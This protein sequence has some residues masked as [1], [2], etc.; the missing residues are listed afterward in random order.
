MTV[1][2]PKPNPAD[3][4]GKPVKDTAAKAP[5]VA[6]GAAVIRRLQ[7][8][9]E[10]AHERLVKKHVPAWVI[11]GAVHL[12]VALALFIVFG[13]RQAEAVQSSKVLDT[14][15]EKETEEPA[16]D[17]TNE[18]PGLESN[19]EAAVPE[20]DR[21][22]EKTVDDVVT[23]DAI[24]IPDPRSEDT[25]ALKAPGLIADSNTGGAPGVDGNVMGGDGGNL[26]MIATGGF[27][28][29]GGATK[30][31]LLRAGGG[32][33]AS[34][35]AVA[36]GLA[37]LA[38]QQKPNG[39]WVYDGQSSGDTIAATGMALLP[40]L[41]AGETHKAGK[42][43]QQTVLRGL[44][45]LI[46][47]QRSDGGFNGGGITMYSHGIATIALNEAY[48][49][50]K[51]KNMLLRPAQAAT[52]FIV[53]KQGSD[54]SWGYAP[55]TTGD[56]SIVGW[57]VQA[58]KAGILSK[59][60]VVPD[61]TI[62]DA[63]KFLDKVSSGS[64]KAVYGYTAPNGAPGTSLTAVGLLCRYYISKWGPGNAGLAE[65]VEGLMKRPPAKAPTAPDMYY[66]YYSTQVVHF[67]DGPEWKDWNEGPMVNGKRAGGMRDWLI[68]LQEKKEGPTHG[69][70]ASDGAII[71]GHCGRIG[72]TSLALLTLE[73]YYR[74][75]PLYKREGAGGNKVLDGLK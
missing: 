36:M 63:I 75:L 62:Q 59:D 6:G 18:D 35:R 27:A 24:G 51:D 15:A 73:V 7:G 23:N 31:Q 1:S 20:I 69:S 10:T 65:G 39:S 45:Y 29:R 2:A 37:W 21:L 49:M 50:S 30:S 34:E 32:N 12:V 26:G 40:F 56:T 72:T 71:G 19:L 11:S 60:I 52:N 66:Y 44:Q 57:Q 14:T 5:G 43:Y 55:G 48:G 70:W 54:G 67:A 28:G 38:R 53:A 3:D 74:H 13:G 17:L 41:A 64:R 42:K 9:E 25:V 68:N 47:Q 33:E 58:L 61:K 46:S 8:T 22:A 4:N 16:K